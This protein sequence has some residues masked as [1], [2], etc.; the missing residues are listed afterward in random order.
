[1]KVYNR[2]ES[3]P[4]HFNESN[5]AANKA[6]YGLKMCCPVCGCVGVDFFYFVCFCFFRARES[7][8]EV[9]GFPV[10]FTLP[11]S[12][13][14]SVLCLLLPTLYNNLC[15]ITCTDIT[16]CVGSFLFWS[17]SKGGHR[18][19]RYV[20]LTNVFVSAGFYLISLDK[21]N[22]LLAVFVSSGTANNKDDIMMMF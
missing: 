7:W 18:R 4:T 21:I 22:V 8:V 15:A 6:E 11:F 1:M 5:G 20:L 14:C 19:P 2:G 3:A 17:R 10:F 12:P 13:C 16:Q 9:C